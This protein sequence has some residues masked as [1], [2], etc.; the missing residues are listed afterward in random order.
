[1][2][3]K[4]S[5]IQKFKIRLAFESCV[6]VCIF[7]YALFFWFDCANGNFYAFTKYGES[8]FIKY[9]ESPINFYWAVILKSSI[10]IF[11]L[12]FLFKDLAKR[13]KVLFLKST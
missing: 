2:K 7:V 10:F 4:L 12:Y 6:F 5:K 9:S 8:G 11:L 13:I 1:V 3:M